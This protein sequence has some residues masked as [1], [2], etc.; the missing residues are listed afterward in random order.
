VNGNLNINTVTVA[1]KIAQALLQGKDKPALRNS[2]RRIRGVTLDSQNGQAL[3][4]G[5]PAMK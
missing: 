3:K 2:S 4:R 5:P 1:V